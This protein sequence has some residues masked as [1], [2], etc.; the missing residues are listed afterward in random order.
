M[1]RESS[2]GLDRLASLLSHLL[3]PAG[4]AAAV[5]AVLGWTTG[6]G[7]G[8]TLLGVTAL[9]LTPAGALMVLVVRHRMD[10]AYDPQP[11]LRQSFLKLGSLC[12]GLGYALFEA[13]QL[14]PGIRW[15][16]A[17]FAAGAVS[18][19]LIDRRWK[20]SIHNT[21]AG[22]GAVL[23][24]SST[25]PALWPVWCALP[26]VVGWARLRRKAHSPAQLAA[27]AALGA[28]VTLLLRGLYL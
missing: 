16:G 4:V 23:L 17:S 10:D 7:A 13:L 26:V 28:G 19:W 6:T 27:G 9:A 18:V 8:A 21:G 3:N 11:P 20:I 12:Y 24:G 25:A 15:A 2:R 22:G 1:T 14:H 5:C